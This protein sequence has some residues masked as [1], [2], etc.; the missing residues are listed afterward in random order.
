M[1]LSAQVFSFAISFSVGFL[2]LSAFAFSHF[3]AQFVQLLPFSL[4]VGTLRAKEEHDEY[5]K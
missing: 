3:L 2:A 5:I 4:S 1:P